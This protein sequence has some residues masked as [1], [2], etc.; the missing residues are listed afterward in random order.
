MARATEWEKEIAEA[1]RVEQWSLVW[2]RRIVKA[3]PL[4]RPVVSR[5]RGYVTIEK[6]ILGRTPRQLEDDLGLPPGL[7]AKGCRVYWL[8][9]LPRAE[10]VSYE[11][12][13]QYPGGLAFDEWGALNEVLLRQQ[14][15]GHNA[16]PIYA[17]GRST[18]HQWELLAE[19][20]VQVAATLPPNIPYPTG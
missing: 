9:R 1:R 16:K 13:A 14:N 4:E 8:T 20:P 2:P 15:P 19:L 11:L 17:P 12:T 7:F 18:I 10:E 3:V 6:Y 5:V